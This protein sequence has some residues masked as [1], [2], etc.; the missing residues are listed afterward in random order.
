MPSRRITNPADPGRCKGSK[1]TGQCENRAEEGSDYCRC[2]AP[3]KKAM[4]PRTRLYHLARA[5]FHTRLWEIADHED[6][7]ST[8]EELALA[9]MLLEDLLNS[10]SD[11]LML[12]AK[13]PAIQRQLALIGRLVKDCY[14]LEQNNGK[15]LHKQTGLQAAYDIVVLV[16]GYLER[17]PNSEDL[18]DCVVEEIR[19]LVAQEACLDLGT[20]AQKS[21]YRLMGDQQARLDATAS[22]GSWRSLRVEIAAGVLVLERLYN[23]I[24][25]P[26]MLELHIDPIQRMLLTVASLKRD[27]S[28]LERNRDLLIHKERLLQLAAKVVDIVAQ[29]LQ[30]SPVSCDI[31]QLRLDVQRVVV[32]AANM[33]TAKSIVLLPGPK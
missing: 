13:A 27:F 25:D 26:S 32:K 31:P 9:R 1:P 28:A 20:N 23:S 2:C 18:K 17:V 7:K 3:P 10:I 22:W 30:S 16:C 5:D 21:L 8:R 19:R 33:D 12:V 6:L 4:T 11:D 24:T 15:L 29:R 14:L